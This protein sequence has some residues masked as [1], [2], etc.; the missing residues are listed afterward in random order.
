MAEGG[1]TRIRSRNASEQ[2]LQGLDTSSTT[3]E[4]AMEH[5]Q[6]IIENSPDPAVEQKASKLLDTLKENDKKPGDLLSTFERTEFTEI[7]KRFKS[8]T[9]Q[10]REVMRQLV[11]LG[12]EQRVVHR[13]PGRD[14]GHILNAYEERL[15]STK[16]RLQEALDRINVLNQE[17]SS[18]RSQQSNERIIFEREIASMREEKTKDRALFEDEIR[19]LRDTI[20]RLEED[21]RNLEQQI[22]ELRE[23]MEKERDRNDKFKHDQKNLLEQMSKTHMEQIGQLKTTVDMLL[24]ENKKLK[25]KDPYKLVGYCVTLITNALYKFVHGVE[26]LRKNYYSIDNLENHLATGYQGDEHGRQ[27]AETRW[28]DIKARIGWNDSAPALLNQL[29]ETREKGANTFKC[30]VNYEEFS[31]AVRVMFSDKEIDQRETE[32]IREIFVKCDDN[33]PMQG[34]LN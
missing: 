29:A 34:N 11:E 30:T 7:V 15:S 20:R 5:L 17:L 33:L 13:Q 12:V 8:C 2:S 1:E 25:T 28:E 14:I 27:A 4:E 9:K 19:T 6:D 3:K 21:K 18:L 23:Q 16:Q 10:V 32:L 22:T 26:R 31:E 24:E